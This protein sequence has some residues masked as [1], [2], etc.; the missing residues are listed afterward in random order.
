MDKA[1]GEGALGS[2]L[3]RRTTVSSSDTTAPL[4]SVSVNASVPSRAYLNGC[5]DVDCVTRESRVCVCVCVCVRACV[6]V[7]VSVCVCARARVRAC[8][9]AH[10]R[11]PAVQRL[12]CITTCQ[13]RQ[14]T[15]RCSTHPYLEPDQERRRHGADNVRRAQMQQAPPTPWARPC[16]TSSPPIGTAD[17]LPRA[18]Q[19]SG[20][21]PARESGAHLPSVKKTSTQGRAYRVRETTQ[22]PQGHEQ[23]MCY[24]R[25][26][27]LSL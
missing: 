17:V 19:A 25:G 2:P 13:A 3:T 4:E 12:F 6:C 5:C 18:R 15:G 10:I 21:R 24:S 16:Q 9:C 7:C 14:R 8:V 26:V 1:V 23:D 27:C 11:V 22:W 20:K